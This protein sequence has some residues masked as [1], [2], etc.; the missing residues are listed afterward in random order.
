[1]L[2]EITGKEWG[3]LLYLARPILDAIEGKGPLRS[4]RRRRAP[5]RSMPKA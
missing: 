1:M 4:F 2:E 3:R 5:T